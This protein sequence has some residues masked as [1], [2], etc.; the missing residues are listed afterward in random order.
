[1]VQVRWEGV[2]LV[3]CFHHF[4]VAIYVSNVCFIA[5]K[6]N[7]GFSDVCLVVVTSD[8]AESY[9]VGGLAVYLPSRNADGVGDDSDVGVVL[10]HL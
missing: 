4:G 1:M 6:V 5:C 9:F 8:V 3:W 2:E 7:G 10:L